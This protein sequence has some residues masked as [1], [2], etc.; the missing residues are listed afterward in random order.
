MQG[1]TRAGDPHFIAKKALGMLLDGS[2]NV[3]C[4]TA[5]ARVSISNVGASVRTT[6]ASSKLPHKNKPALNCEK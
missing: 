1:P 4:C 2:H 6:S 3:T 5:S